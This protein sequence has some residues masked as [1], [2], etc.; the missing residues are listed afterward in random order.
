[1]ATVVAPVKASGV[2][3]KSVFAG[4]VAAVAISGLLTAFGAA[5]GLSL[6]SPR[7]NSGI[8]VTTLAIAAALWMVM[9]HVWSFAVGGY[10][11]GRLSDV[12]EAD[13][14]EAQFRAGA[15]GFM[16]WALGTAVG[17]VFLAFAAGTA[18]KST[19]ELA[20][21]TISGA[22]QAAS[23]ASSNI[24]SEN[25]SYIADA[26]FRAQAQPGATPGGA[27]DRVDPGLVAEAG[28]I[29]A[30][31]LAEGSLSSSDR[32]YLAS[33]VSRQTGLEQADAQRR[34]D[35]TYARAQAM[36]DKAA[37][38]VRDAADKARKQAVIVG[39]LTA[40]ASLMGLVAATWA[41]GIGWEHQSTRQY[42]NLFASERFW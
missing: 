42:P 6:T 13:P 25:V 14:P 35:E 41:A 20:G 2:D 27:Q 38:T 26:L 18:A 39:F 36:K 28:R 8:S 29:I 16:V 9:V 7:Q 10:L 34:V 30:V 15:N 4:A 32:D 11:A 24:S 23:N 40:A 12:P 3:W 33:I 22:A 1:M 17:L 21:R 31:G 5:V 19:A 37:Q